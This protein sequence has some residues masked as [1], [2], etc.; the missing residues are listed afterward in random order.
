MF[1]GPPRESSL[2]SGRGLRY[3]NRVLTLREEFTNLK[4]VMLTKAHGAGN[5]FV[6]V[7]DPDGALDLST[8]EV[9]RICDRHLGIGGDGL[10]RV[11]RSAAVP[12]AGA[13]LGGAIAAPEWFMDY[14][15]ADGTIAE[16][17][18][19]GVRVF[20][21]YVRLRGLIELAPGESVAIGTRGGI[22][23]VTFDAPNYTVD[24][25]ESGL[26]CGTGGA[27]TLVDIPGIGEREGLSVTMPN[28]HTVV[29]LK[30]GGELAAANFH[31]TPRYSPVPPQGTNLEIVVP[32]MG[33]A[34]TVQ[35]RV[36]E[37]GVG[38]TLACGTGTCAV[39]LAVLLSR[40]EREG[41][42][43]VHSPG[44]DMSVRIEG[45]RAHLT[46]PAELVA[47]VTLC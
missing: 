20:V 41:V 10:I 29:L 8:T 16:M 38:E 3:S 28:P 21:H 44:G 45:G 24:M 26:P 7:P 2:W 11:V 33:G 5:D 36:L 32:G 17:C 40:G 39:A 4:G 46:G 6:L 1:R 12:D 23:R 18:G 30:D 43:P 25:G 31:A 14:R 27:D 19:N 35:M 15:N 34:S 42:V 13:H 22:K 9:A 47:D 37:R